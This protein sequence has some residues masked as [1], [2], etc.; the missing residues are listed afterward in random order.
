MLE[1]ETYCSSCGV[2]GVGTGC[3]RGGGAAGVGGAAGGGDGAVQGWWCWWQ[4]H[5]RRW[6]G[7]VPAAVV[8]LLLETC[9]SLA[10]SA[11]VVL[12][13]VA[14]ASG[15]LCEGLLLLPA[16]GARKRGL[17]RKNLADSRIS[18]GSMIKPTGPQRVDVA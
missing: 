7:G 14:A 13:L 8:L 11:V 15:V 16:T 1:A 3:N 18:V 10:A 12:V 6:Q 4:R 5:W 17:L 2:A 9:V